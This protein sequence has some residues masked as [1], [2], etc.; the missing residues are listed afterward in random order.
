MGTIQRVM[1]PV[2]RTTFSVGVT[3]FVVVCIAHIW[4]RC[5]LRLLFDVGRGNV[6]CLECNE[7]RW[8]RCG[9]GGA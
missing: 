9:L 4:R 7:G 5:Q 1:E 6:E 8:H 2:R 3:F